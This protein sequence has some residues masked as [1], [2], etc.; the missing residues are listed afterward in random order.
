MAMFTKSL[1]NI[2]IKM[3]LPDT[4]MLHLTCSLTSNKEKVVN[5]VNI[6]LVQ[7]VIKLLSHLDCEKKSQTL[8]KI[9]VLGL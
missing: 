1:I 8:N 4:D 2:F 3:T 5:I 6:N 7:Q 9:N